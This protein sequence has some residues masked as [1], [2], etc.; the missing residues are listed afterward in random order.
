M[1]CVC[2]RPVDESGLNNKAQ[3]GQFEQ[4]VNVIDRGRCVGITKV[5]ILLRQET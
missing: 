1:G 2:A 5:F 4:A 3:T